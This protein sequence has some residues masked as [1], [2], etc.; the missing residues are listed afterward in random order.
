MTSDVLM[1]GRTLPLGSSAGASDAQ[2]NART[3]ARTASM[4]RAW[5]VLSAPHLLTEE[6]PSGPRKM[7]IQA[8]VYGPKGGRSRSARPGV[9]ALHGFAAGK[10]PKASLGQA[11]EGPNAARAAIEIDLGPVEDADLEIEVRD[12]AGKSPHEL[13]LPAMQIPGQGVLLEH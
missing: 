10:G 5:K 8:G 2:P 6:A 3:I 12:T 7:E 1:I 11:T 9:L 4:P 13:G